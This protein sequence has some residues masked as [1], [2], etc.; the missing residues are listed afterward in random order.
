MY[1]CSLE[2]VFVLPVSGFT[3]RTFS[4]PLSSDLSEHIT[5][6]TEDDI[7]RK[8]PAPDLLLHNKCSVLVPE[9]RLALKT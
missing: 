7:Q 2:P 5:A 8:S 9:P 1:L 4:R 6:F 3:I